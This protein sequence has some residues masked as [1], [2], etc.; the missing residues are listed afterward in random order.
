MA[1]TAAKQPGKYVEVGIDDIHEG[2]FK[3]AIDQIVK[4]CHQNLIR[5]VDQTADMKGRAKFVISGEI[6]LNGDEHISVDYATKAPPIPVKRSAVVRAS[7]G[8][9]LKAIDGSDQSL[10]DKDQLMLPTFDRYGNPKAKVNP[11]T[12]EIEDDD[13]DEA[14]AGSISSA[15]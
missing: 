9:M 4:Q 14:V 15:S 5:Y 8:R 7:Q 6:S 2:D 13:A 3:K 11:A 10:N 1:G 12:G